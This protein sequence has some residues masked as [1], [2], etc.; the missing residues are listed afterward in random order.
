[1]ASVDDHLKAWLSAYLGGDERLQWELTNVR[2][3]VV[4]ECDGETETTEPASDLGAVTAV[5]DRRTLFLVGGAADDG[6]DDVASVPHGEVAGVAVDE[7]FLARRL[8]VTTAAGATWR[9]TTRES[10]ALDEAV[11]YIDDRMEGA[12]HVTAALDA[13]R[14]QRETAETVDD[15]AAAAAQYDEA[16]DGFRQAVALRTAPAVESDVDPDTV[17]EEVLET[18]EAAIESHLAWA[19]E[20]RSLGNWEYQAGA[21]TAAYD[22]L[23]TALNAFER[24]LELACECPPGDADAIGAERDDLL[25]KLDDLEIRGAVVTAGED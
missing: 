21:E 16:V 5:T 13:A 20:E 3:G 8:V 24:A 1:M 12:D 4:R 18:V 14:T 25:A 6:R 9:F 7:D 15:H 22:H 11:A 17:R 23:S 19:R 2:S 10:D